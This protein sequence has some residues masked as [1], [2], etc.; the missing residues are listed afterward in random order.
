MNWYGLEHSA[1]AETTATEAT[2]GTH[3]ALTTKATTA[4]HATLAHTH[5]LALSKD[6]S[7]LLGSEGLLEL[8]Q[9]LLF[10]L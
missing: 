3:T 2:A 9:I 7:N 1:T 10:N 5:L 6:L 8:S 4:L